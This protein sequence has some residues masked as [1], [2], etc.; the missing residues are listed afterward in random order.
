MEEE[1]EEEEGDIPAAVNRTRRIPAYNN[2]LADSVWTD[3]I[4]LGFKR[5]LPNPQCPI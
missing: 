1:E 2:P 5:Y 3:W 4:I